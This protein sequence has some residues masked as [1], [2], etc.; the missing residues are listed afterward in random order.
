MTSFLW[1]G[2][3]SSGPKIIIIRSL[4]DT[5]EGH[6]SLSERIP[7]DFSIKTLW[8]LEKINDFSTTKDKETSNGPMNKEKVVEKRKR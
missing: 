1:P 6:N 5:L 4:N 8:Q 7:V 2:L 3:L